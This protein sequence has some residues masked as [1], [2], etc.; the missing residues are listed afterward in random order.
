MS[1]KQKALPQTS[2]FFD[3]RLY[4]LAPMLVWTLVV[5]ASLKWNFYLLDKKLINMMT[6]NSRMMFKLIEGIHLLNDRYGDLYVQVSRYMKP[7]PYLRESQRD[8]HAI[9]GN[10]LAML[11]PEQV[12]RQLAKINGAQE[13]IVF[14]LS[15]RNPTKPENTADTWEA[16]ALIAFEKGVKDKTQLMGYRVFRYMAPLTI[17][18]T[19]LRC[20]RHKQSKAGEIRGGLSVTFSSSPY[21]DSRGIE[22]SRIVLYHGVVFVVLTSAILSFLYMLRRQRLVLKDNSAAMVKQSSEPGTTDLAED[23]NRLLCIEQALQ[24]SD[25]RYNSLIQAIQEGIISIDAEGNIIGFNKEACSLFGY[26]QEEVIGKPLTLFIPNRHMDTYMRGLRFIQILGDA[27]FAGKRIELEGVKKDGSEF[28]FDLSVVSWKARGIKCYTGIMRDITSRKQMEEQ[29]RAS[30]REKEVLLR[31]VRHRV[32]NNMQIITSLLNLQIGYIEDEKVREVFNETRNRIKVM[33]LIHESLYQADSLD[34]IPFAQYIDNLARALYRSYG[35]SS[36][37]ITMIKKIPELS[38]GID[39]AI[40]CGLVINELLSNSL[41]YAFPS[42]VTG[43]V[44][45]ALKQLNQEEYE[46]TVWDN[47][48]GIDDNLDIRNT[49]TLGLQL[50]TSI[51]EKQLNGSISLDSSFG[52]SF[53]I[54]FKEI[55]YPVKVVNSV[56]SQ[57]PTQGDFFEPGALTP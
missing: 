52:T 48:V 37:K 38:L 34:H 25:K 49:E 22:R 15:S 3:S 2:S 8:L 10:G 51:V 36:S 21:F 5:S 4:W 6:Q 33:S 44:G 26:E 53:T 50:V 35:V 54:R 7:N 17:T 9:E 28:F 1:L 32:K 55:K 29:I 24:E 56:T 19:C 57:P 12:L 13:G 47:G 18:D 20:H 16:E 14:H 42:A 27:Y 40:A 30:V 11:N 23:V 39:T 41:K 43:E 46:I 31:E 45:I